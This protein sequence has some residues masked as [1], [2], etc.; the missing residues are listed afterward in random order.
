MGG[1]QD[2]RKMGGLRQ[3]LP[4]TSTTFI[5]A[6]LAIAGIPP[7][8]GFFSKDEILWQAF[9]SPYGGRGLWAVG[10]L[11]AFLT[12]FYMFRQVFMV[13]YGECRADHETQH[14][15]HESP[16][17]MT[18]PLWILAGGS[19]VAGWLWVPHLFLPFEHWLEPVMGHPAGHGEVATELTLMVVSVVVAVLGIGLAWLMYYRGAFSPDTFASAIGGLPHRLVYNKYYVDEIY[20]LIFVRGGLALFRLTA[21]F[22][23]NVIDGIVNLSAAVV[24]A[25]AWIGGKFDTWVVDGAVNLVATITQFTGRRIRNLQT[26]AINAY[27]Y[28]VIMGVLA[29][30]LLYWSW[31]SA[32]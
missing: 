24:R 15:I 10:L 31:A 20:E 30:V 16:S 27:L 13:F 19:V 3:K 28:V 23:N 18:L 21:W 4:A 14:H 12:A 6:T 29:S 17:T 5:I 22:D 32:S 26:G 25:W 9:S 8:A 7:L 11:V 1:E 2:M